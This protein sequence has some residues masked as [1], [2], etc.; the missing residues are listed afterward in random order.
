MGETFSAF[1]GRG[2]M[3]S[4]NSMASVLTAAGTFRCAIYCA[5]KTAIGCQ[6]PCF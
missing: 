5:S 2:N 1:K 3:Q 6:C 4:M